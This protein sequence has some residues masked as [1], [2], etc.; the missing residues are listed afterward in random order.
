MRGGN[1]VSCVKEDRTSVLRG[2]WMAIVN[3]TS[4]RASTLESG[5]A[6]WKRGKAFFSHGVK[7][8]SEWEMGLMELWYAL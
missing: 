2:R 3:R 5:S 1:D 4:E 8:E 6:C 7:E